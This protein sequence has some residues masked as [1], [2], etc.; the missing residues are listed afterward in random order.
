M[1][2][3]A[4]T[5]RKP[6]HVNETLNDEDFE[7]VCIKPIYLLRIHSVE[8]SILTI[9]LPPSSLT[10]ESKSSDAITYTRVEYI[11]NDQ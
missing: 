3:R 2:I 9:T 7:N 6:I 10:E 1:M 4:L 8:H 5:R 11:F